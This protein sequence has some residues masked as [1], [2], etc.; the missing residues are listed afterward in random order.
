MSKGGGDG[1]GDHSRRREGVECET[2]AWFGC[3]VR[4]CDH[5]YTDKKNLKDH[6]IR[7]HRLIPSDDGRSVGGRATSRQYDGAMRAYQARM[8]KAREARAAARREEPRRGR[9]REEEKRLLET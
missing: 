8:D 3:P 9:D 7:E 5:R 6:M 1:E 2:G 4:P